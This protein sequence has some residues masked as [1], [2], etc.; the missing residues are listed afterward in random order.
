MKKEYKKPMIMV[1]NF[2]LSECIAS[3]DPSFTNNMNVDNFIADITGFTGYFT[4]TGEGCYR[5]VEPGKDYEFND[6][7]LCYHTS[8]NVVFSS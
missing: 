8:S 5:E 6:I 4:G 3:C 7:I 1:E 2:L